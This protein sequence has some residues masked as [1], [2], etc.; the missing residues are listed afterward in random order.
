M[1]KYVNLILALMMSIAA[2]NA[3]KPAADWREKYINAPE[4][5]SWQFEKGASFNVEVCSKA[6][7]YCLGYIL[8]NDAPMSVVCRSNMK[9]ECPAD[10]ENCGT[11]DQTI[12]FGTVRAKIAPEVK[13]GEGGT[14]GGAK[15]AD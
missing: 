2:A 1:G 4:E 13:P 10:P 5:N 12:Q 9:G 7:K 11:N 14:P 3:Q 6:V 15:V 8:V